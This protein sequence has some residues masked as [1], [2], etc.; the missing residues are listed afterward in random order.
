MGPRHPQQA[1]LYLK[2]EKC[3]F[4]QPTVE[5]LG[6]I[7]SEGCVEMD[8]IKVAGI[9]DWLTPTSMTKVQSFVRFINFYW[10]FIQ[11]FSHVAKSLHQLTKKGEAWR[12]TEA[13]QEAFDTRKLAKLRG[14]LNPMI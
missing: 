6:L 1:Q 14:A 9:H 13:E 10:Q 3:T 12:W 11:D 7:L 8:P 5:Y 4:G 2:A